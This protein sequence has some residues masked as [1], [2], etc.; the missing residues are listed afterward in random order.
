MTITKLKNPKTD[1]YKNFKSLVLGDNFPWFY[2]GNFVHKGNERTYK[3][4]AD[5]GYSDITFLSHSFLMRPLQLDCRP[6]ILQQVG[7]L[8]PNVNSN[9]I[10][11][12]DEVLNEIFVYNKH[13][14]NCIYRMNANM[15]YPS[16]GRQ[17]TLPH[18]DHGF[19][20]KNLIVY[21]TDAGGKTV[22]KSDN[23]LGGDQVH[24]PQEDDIITFSGTHYIHLPKKDR[25]VV[26][27]V[28]YV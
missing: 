15:I 6:G 14:V 2:N 12:C 19:P 13:S 10:D 1:T 18:V 17:E 21:L 27:I 8:Y 4:T 20:H 25:R 3:K 11:S 28:T 22:C 9:Y 5:D 16:E 7:K 26:I 24:D 23:I